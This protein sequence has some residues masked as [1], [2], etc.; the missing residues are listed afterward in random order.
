MVLLWAIALGAFFKFVLNEGIARWQLATGMTALEGWAEYLPA[1]VKVYFGLYLVFWTVAVSAALTNATGLGIAQPHAAARSPQS[2]GA[3]L[4]S[5]F[6]FAFVLARRL[7]RFEKLMKT[8]VGLMGF[9]ILVCAILHVP[10]PARHAAGAV[11][12]DDPARERHLRAVDHRRHR[13]LDHDAVVQ[14]L[15]AR[16]EDQ[17]RRATLGYVRGDIAVAY[18]FTALFGISIMLIAN[19]AFFMPASDHAMRRR[20]RRWRR[21]WAASSDRLAC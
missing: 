3:V 4:H 21:C 19:Q 8:L 7:R 15:D 6:G 16:R 5:L 18:L 20:C 14:L 9:S 2:W 12:P 17:R 13:R 1:W 11:G 10:R